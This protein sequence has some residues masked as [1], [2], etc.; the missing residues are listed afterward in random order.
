MRHFTL[1]RKN[2]RPEGTTTFGC[3]LFLIIAAVFLYFGF[4]FGSAYWNYFEVKYK[5]Q[6]T[7]NWAVAG[8]TKTEPEIMQK[9]MVNATEVGVSLKPRNI[10]IKQTADSLIISVFWEKELEFPYYTFPLKFDVTLAGEKRW[11]RGPLLVK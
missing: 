9:I 6:E 8:T 2:K 7:L 10:Q 11:H 3:L 1:F 5:I 4:K